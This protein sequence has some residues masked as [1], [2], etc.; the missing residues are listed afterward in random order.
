LYKIYTGEDFTCIKI[1]KL[2]IWSVQTLKNSKKIEN[3]SENIYFGQCL[4]G[5]CM[6]MARDV[7]KLSFPKVGC[8]TISVCKVVFYI[9]MQLTNQTLSRAI[10]RK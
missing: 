9:V 6:Y 1:M 4:S 10:S 5:V 7:Y 2:R 8:R 3:E